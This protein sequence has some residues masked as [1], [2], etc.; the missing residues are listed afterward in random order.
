MSLTAITGLPKVQQRSVE[1]LIDLNLIKHRRSGEEIM[2]GFRNT[3]IVR[4]LALNA[5]NISQTAIMLQVNRTLLIRWMRKY[6]LLE[7]EDQA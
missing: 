4:A 3:L 6:G 5:G 1:A 2:D 7:S